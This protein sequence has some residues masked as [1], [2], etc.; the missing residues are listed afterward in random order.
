MPEKKVKK[1]QKREPDIGDVIHYATL[2]V[3]LFAILVFTSTDGVKTIFG[4]SFMTVL[5][6]SMQDEIPQGSLVI[7]KKTEPSELKIGDDITY[8]SGSDVTITHR[9]IDI[10]IDENG[11]TWFQTQGI[12][13]KYPDVQL[14]S[15]LNVVGK[16]IF[17]NYVLGKVLTFMKAYFGLGVIFAAIL[18][19]LYYV[20]KKIN[21][22]DNENEGTSELDKA[23]LISSDEVYLASQEEKSNE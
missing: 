3:L 21:A 15:E 23:K 20:L 4:Y 16:V 13:N 14:I 7:N 17:H 9:I 12:M 22:D 2:V 10:T 8:L 6:G 18:T 11:M 5:T 1:K 19:G